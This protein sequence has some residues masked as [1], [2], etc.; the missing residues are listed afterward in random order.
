MTDPKLRDRVGTLLR[1][2]LHD[3]EF[4]IWHGLHPRAGT[5][6]Q[7]PSKGPVNR[8]HLY[9]L[10]SA[11]LDLIETQRVQ[12]PSPADDL[13]EVLPPHNGRQYPH[14]H[15][16]DGYL[17]DVVTKGYRTET[18]KAFMIEVQVSRVPEHGTNGGSREVAEMVN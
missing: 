7:T 10:T 1:G 11:I 15:S 17:T 12:S 5:E 2:K 16:A 14:L 8:E 13:L 6:D 3:H 4:T 9:A 18:T